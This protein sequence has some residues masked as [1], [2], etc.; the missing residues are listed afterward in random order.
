MTWIAFFLILA[1]VVLHAGWHFLSK[2]RQPTCAFFLLVS[3]SDFL[4]TLPFALH[5]GLELT[6]LPPRFY[7]LALGGGLSGTLCDL[8][9]ST[10]YRKTEVSLAYP[11]ARALPV[12][13]TAALTIALGLGARPGP[14]AL[15]GMVVLFAGC[16][17][18]PLVRFSDFRPASYW[19]PALGGILIA[20]LGTTGYTIFDSQALK[21]V[22]Q[23]G[24][25]SELGGAIGYMALRESILFSGL[26]LYILP[27]RNQRSCFTRA[28]F[29]QWHPYLAGVFA[30][31]AYVLILLAM[32]QVTNVSYVQA[33][34]QLS[35]PLGVL[36][37]VLILKERCTLSKLLGMCLVV[38]GLILTALKS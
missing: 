31:L 19:N 9:L 20:A 18:M 34:R 3:A 21:L 4:F 32:R 5:S 23:Y 27:Q 38:A 15:T 36:L 12:L 11:L 7:W 1:S 16:L 29:R 25:T 33:F 8:G 17:L 30:A 10:A 24:N 2:S 26:A 22:A 6:N 37:G 28:L 35:L 13:F 14:L